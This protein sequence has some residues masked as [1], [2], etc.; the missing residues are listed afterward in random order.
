MNAET[1]TML[2]QLL[3][4]TEEFKDSLTAQDRSTWQEIAAKTAD[5]RE[6]EGE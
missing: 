2:E 5:L 3:S 6:Q 1:L 4:I